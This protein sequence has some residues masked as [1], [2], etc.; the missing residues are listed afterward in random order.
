MSKLHR[1][2]RLTT[3][4]RAYRRRTD[5]CSQ[6]PAR[7]WVEP[8]SHCNL[9]CDF[10]LNRK[11][12]RDQKG[13]M[14]I[15]LFRDLVDQ[16]A[17]S[18]SLHGGVHQINLFH[19][20]ES[21]LHPEIGSMIGYASSAGLQTRVHTNGT[22]MDREKALELLDSGLDI[23]SFSFD[24]YD[25][26]MYE[27]NRVNA[28]FE[29]TLD[30]ITGLLKVKRTEAR[31]KPFVALELMEIGDDPPDMMRRKRVDFLRRFKGLPL[32]KFVIRTPHNWGGGV[33]VGK[34]RSGRLLREHRVPCPLLWHALAVFWDGS[35]MPCCQ[36][37]FGE[38][39]LG[40][41]KESSIED[42]WNGDRMR[43]LRREMSAVEAGQLRMPCATCDRI[44]RTTIAGVP[45]DYIGRFLSE[46]VLNYGW[47]SKLLPH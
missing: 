7:I 45:T 40:N 35:V 6:P 22:V 2:A 28:C 5:I 12:G 20:G 34:E 3:T 41:L 32:D 33:N 18:K 19:R 31:R 9:R 24:G 30:N 10:C 43:E 4:Y 37:F 21:L 17:P 44:T 14:D 8:T 36:D 26:Q 29:K 15:G 11:L 38:L 16:I 1:L 39:V 47:L 27:A 25:K 46:N 13:Y 23:L 42:M